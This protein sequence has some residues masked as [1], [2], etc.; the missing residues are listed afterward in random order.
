[1]GSIATGVPTIGTPTIQGGLSD[2]FILG[3]GCPPIPAEIVS[4]IL[5]N[6]FVEMSG[7]FPRTWKH[8]SHSIHYD[9]DTITTQKISFVYYIKYML[10][11]TL[12]RYVAV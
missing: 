11:V 6:K 12:L 10:A 7:S 2:A 1:M 3:P 9:N 5:T 8:R 4:Q